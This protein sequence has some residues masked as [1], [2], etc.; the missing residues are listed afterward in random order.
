MKTKYCW[1]A[2]Q[3]RLGWKLGFCAGEDKTRWL[4]HI[5]LKDEKVKDGIALG[6]IL[7]VKILNKNLRK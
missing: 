2:K 1:I 4:K 3:Y 6:M 5:Y 7:T